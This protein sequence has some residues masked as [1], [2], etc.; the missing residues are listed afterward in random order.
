MTLVSIDRGRV[1]LGESIDDFY[2]ADGSRR[3][4]AEIG[5][6]KE[7]RGCAAGVW[8]VSW[9]VDT[10]ELTAIHSTRPRINATFL[11]YASGL[12]KI[13]VLAVIP[14]RDAL[15]EALTGWQGW[16]IHPRGFSWL[17]ARVG[18]EEVAPPSLRSWLGG[19]L[20]SWRERTR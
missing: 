3:R 12:P 8:S 15:E 1:L 10:G 7:W 20:R 18:V 17:L 11:A 16:E 4:S 13:Y 19:L 14:E 5:Y 2:A 6:G 9:L